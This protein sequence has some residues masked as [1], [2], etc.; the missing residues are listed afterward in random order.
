M[1]END[2]ENNRKKLHTE[3]VKGSSQKWNNDKN[4]M[5]KRDGEGS[6]VDR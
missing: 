2:E 4:V 6:V 5:K 3:I 1:T